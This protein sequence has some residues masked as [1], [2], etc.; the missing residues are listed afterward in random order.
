MFQSQFPK[1]LQPLLILL[2]MRATVDGD[3]GD[4][5]GLGTE[6]YKCTIEN[7]RT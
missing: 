3:K 7:Y 6:R 2:P 1:R 4:H 5:W